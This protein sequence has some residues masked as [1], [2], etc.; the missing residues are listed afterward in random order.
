VESYRFGSE[1]FQDEYDSLACMENEDDNFHPNDVDTKVQKD[2]GSV[3]KD[4]KMLPPRNVNQQDK[5]SGPH[6]R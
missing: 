4:G 5:Y 2:D 6:T 1:G 3:D